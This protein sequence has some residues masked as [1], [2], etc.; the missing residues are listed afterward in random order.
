MFAGFESLSLLNV[1]SEHA[2]FI[3]EL[4]LSYH[5]DALSRGLIDSRDLVYFGS[6][7]TAMLL[8]TRIILGA[9]SW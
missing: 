7:I 2:L 4:G 9:R 8:I 1:W 6:V 5:Y 3:R